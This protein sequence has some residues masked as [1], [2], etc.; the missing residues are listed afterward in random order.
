MACAAEAGTSIW[1]DVSAASTGSTHG[2][3]AINAVGCGG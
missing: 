3:S 2:A 1:G